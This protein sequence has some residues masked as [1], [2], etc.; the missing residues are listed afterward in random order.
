MFL[1]REMF[2]TPGR[3]AIL[4]L[5]SLFE[6]R[7]VVVPDV[8]WRGRVDGAEWRAAVDRMAPPLARRRLADA[9]DTGLAAI[10][11]LLAAKGIAAGR[12]RHLIADTLAQGDATG[13]AS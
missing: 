1:A 8:A 4:V 12:P 9:F 5:V 6:R 2:A 10:E 13:G 11:A 7:V 3:D